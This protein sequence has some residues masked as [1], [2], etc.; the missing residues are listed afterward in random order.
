MGNVALPFT[1]D[2]AQNFG[3]DVRTIT[4]MEVAKMVRKQHKN[5][6]A[7]IRIYLAELN[8]LKIESVDSRLKIQPSDVHLEQLGELKTE[9]TN[10]FLDRRVA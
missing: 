8:Q 6:L 7:D 10:P 3:S 2:K 1:T 5:L 4:S 9:F